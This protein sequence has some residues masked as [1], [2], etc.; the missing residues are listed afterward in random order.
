MEAEIAEQDNSLN[1][2]DAEL[3]K[4]QAVEADLRVSIEQVVR[5]KQQLSER[6]EHLNAL[7]RAAVPSDEVAVEELRGQLSL[8]TALQAWRLVSV[9]P[10]SVAVEYLRGPVTITA[11]LTK[12]LTSQGTV[13]AVVSGLLLD[14]SR[15]RLRTLRHA[16]SLIKPTFKSLPKVPST[17]V[18]YRADVASHPGTAR[19]ACPFGTRNRRHWDAVRCAGARRAFCWHRRCH[20]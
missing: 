13:Q 10:D 3:A 11:Q 8:Q 5:E 15:A 1:T 6:M 16:D 17:H 12:K 19:Q 14:S 20:S 2:L 9:R 4:M 18:F 7:L